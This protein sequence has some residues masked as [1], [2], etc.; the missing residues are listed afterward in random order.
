ML[1]NV[2][3]VVAGLVLNTVAVESSTACTCSEV[4]KPLKSATGTKRTLLSLSMRTPAV[5]LALPISA[6]SEPL[7]EEN[8]HTPSV[9]ASALFSMTTIPV[10]LLAVVSLLSVKLEPPSTLSMESPLEV[11]SS[12]VM[13]VSIAPLVNEG[14]SLIGSMFVVSVSP[15]TETAEVALSVSV[16]KC[17]SEAVVGLVLKVVVVEL[18]TACTVRVPGVP[19]KFVIGRKRRRLSLSTRSAELVPTVPIFS[20]VVPS[21]E[22]CHVPCVLAS[23]ASSAIAIPVKVSAEEPSVT[24]SVVSSN[25][26]PNNEVTVAPAGVVSSFAE[27]RTAPPENDGASLS[28]PTTT[29]T[30]AAVSPIPSVS[31]DVVITTV[32]GVVVEVVYVTEEEE[33]IGYTLSPPTAVVLLKLGSGTKRK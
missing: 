25:T 1:K 26:P 32:D 31:V 13:M 18:S 2:R 28:S 9:L 5:A 10:K 24:A 11:V 3:V 23:D 27:A 19:L 33:S 6:Q 29:D 12:S 17:C 21:E 22:N 30:V 8:C 14:A 15:A 20:H 16:L 7:L 4:A